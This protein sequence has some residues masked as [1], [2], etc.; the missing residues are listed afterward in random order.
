MQHNE[1]EQAVIELCDAVPDFNSKVYGS[2]VLF[3]HECVMISVGDG[4]LATIAQHAKHWAAQQGWEPYYVATSKAAGLYLND[5]HNRTKYTA[6]FK[7]DPTQL[8]SE[9][10]Q[11]IRAVTEMAQLNSPERNS[12]P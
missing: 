8:G 7:F 10:L 11:W 5:K 12:T 1:I 4:V 9:E 6:W 3:C 2:E